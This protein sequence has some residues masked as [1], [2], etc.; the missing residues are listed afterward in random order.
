MSIDQTTLASRLRE[1]REEAGV[2]QEEAAAS[3][4]LPRTAVVQIENGNRVVS[5]LELLR[6][7]KAYR[8]DI[9]DFFEEGA[10]KVEE[11]P[12]LVLYR[13]SDTI[14][15]NV[16]LR[17]EVDRCLEICRAGAELEDILDV[18]KRS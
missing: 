13:L 7:A 10:L 4:K 6:F 17:R 11:G 1:A 3:L 9:G 12:E 5:S 2:T 15:Q 8:R 14:G 18:P 16:D